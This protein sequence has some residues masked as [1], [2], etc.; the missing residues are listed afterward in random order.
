M[1]QRL[2]KKTAGFFA[3]NEAADK[4]CTSPERLWMPFQGHIVRIAGKRCF[5]IWETG[6]E[7][8]GYPD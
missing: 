6:P 7:I 8:H 2:I 4:N 5:D 1:I 3:Q